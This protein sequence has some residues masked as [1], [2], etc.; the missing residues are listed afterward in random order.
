MALIHQ[1]ALKDFPEKSVGR[2]AFSSDLVDITGVVEGVTVGVICAVSMG[3]LGLGGAMVGLELLGV[4][5]GLLGVRGL[6]TGGTMDLRLTGSTKM[7]VG[8]LRGSF[9]MLGVGAQGGESIS[10][11]E[12]SS[13]PNARENSPFQLL[14]MAK[15]RSYTLR[16]GTEKTL[17]LLLCIVYKGDSI[18]DYLTW[19]ILIRRPTSVKHSVSQE[20]RGLV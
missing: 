16:G 6:V 15:V 18:L 8:S 10:M 12:G 3:V 14:M 19:V 2:A 4:F 13:L 5:R 11:S 9:G 1:E 7:L 17:D 20:Q